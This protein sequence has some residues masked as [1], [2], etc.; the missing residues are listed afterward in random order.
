MWNDSNN[1]AMDGSGLPANF[2]ATANAL[3]GLA[4]YAKDALLVMDDF[5]PSGRPGDGGIQGVTER[6]F[7]G[8]GNHQGRSR[9]A[10]DGGLCPPRP[11]RALV[12]ATGE[13]VPRRQSIRARLL[14]VEVGAGDVERGQLSECQRGEEEGRLAESSSVS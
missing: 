7:R 12:L 9:M 1:A 3:E 13:E 6:L 11:P 14:I 8:A 4:F 5:A 10:G 2:A